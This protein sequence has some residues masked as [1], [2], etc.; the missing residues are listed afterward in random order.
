MLLVEPFPSLTTILAM[1][2]TRLSSSSSALSC[3]SPP[4]MLSICFSMLPVVPLS[5]FCLPSKALNT[6]SKSAS[7]LTSTS[8]FIPGPAGNESTPISS[9]CFAMFSA[10]LYPI[11][12]ILCMLLV[13]PLPELATI[14][15][16][17]FTRL[18]IF[19]V[20]CVISFYLYLLATLFSEDHA[21]S[22]YSLRSTT[23]D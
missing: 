1:S 5:V 20:L 14:L 17:S 23:A 10:L 2:F 18:S 16:T 4:S 12:N 21:M 7:V 13:E 9:N 19:S 15:A 8:R 11:S 22:A 6:H 3:P